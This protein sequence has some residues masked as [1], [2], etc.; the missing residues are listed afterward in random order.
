MTLFY[1]DTSALVKR[2]NIE[3][4]SDF[5]NQLYDFLKRKSERILTSKISEVEVASAIFRL[6]R[7]KILTRQDALSILYAFEAESEKFID[8]I[9]LSD[10]I[11]YGSKKLLSSYALRGMDSIQLSSAIEAR[12]IDKDVY[13]V[14]DDERLCVYAEGEG[15]TVLRPRS[16][17]SKNW[18]DSF[19]KSF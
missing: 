3:N 11:V 2:Y 14:A 15:F 12:N 8:F 7:E 5:I 13:F 1:F 9:L 17:N 4:G 6:S 18:L 16:I 19:I 10:D